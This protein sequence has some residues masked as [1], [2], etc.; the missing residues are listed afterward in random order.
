M[1]S[2]ALYLTICDLSL[3]VDILSRIM[4][5]QKHCRYEQG[6]GEGLL[7]TRILLYPDSY[8]IGQIEPVLAATAAASNYAMKTVWDL[9]QC[10]TTLWR[11]ENY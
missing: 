11:L 9:G 7:A 10:H 5:R 8:K 3:K 6:A 2:T 1:K 4:T